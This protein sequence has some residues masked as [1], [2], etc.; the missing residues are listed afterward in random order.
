MEKPRILSIDDEPNFTDM[1]R[2]YFAPR[3]YK[4]DIASDGE[5]GMELLN[6][7]EYDVAILDLKMAGLSGEQIMNE[8]KK[9]EK[10][11]KVIFVSAYTDSGRTKTRLLE[12]G[13]YAFLE[14]PLTSLKDLEDLINKAAGSG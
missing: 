1:L 8:I 3:G 12:G 2:Q 4:I 14:K 7:N 10:G 5:R 11:M 9:R 13:A 6:S